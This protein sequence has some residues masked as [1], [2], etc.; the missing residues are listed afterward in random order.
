[1]SVCVC[2]CIAGRS[3]LG[4][5]LGCGY[6]GIGATVIVL[7]GRCFGRDP[8][9]RLLERCWARSSMADGPSSARRTSSFAPL[10]VTDPILAPVS[11]SVFLDLLPAG[12][13]YDGLCPERGW[14]RSPPKAGLGRGCTAVEAGGVPLTVEPACTRGEGRLSMRC[15]TWKDAAHAAFFS[16]CLQST[17]AVV[18]QGNFVCWTHSNGRKGLASM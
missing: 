15:M 2:V 9:Q 16:H 14:G 6:G 12:K 3:G 13:Q 1:M 11:R 8:R 5:E 7:A 18:G 4:G 10:A 17:S